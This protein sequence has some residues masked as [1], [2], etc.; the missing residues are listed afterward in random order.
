MFRKRNINNNKKAEIL[1]E[2][3]DN[4]NSSF[5]NINQILKLKNNIKILGKKR[6]CTFSTTEEYLNDKKKQKLNE[7][8]FY[9]STKTLFENNKNNAIR[10]NLIDPELPN[11]N[12]KTK[13]DSD[14]KFFGYGPIIAP[15]NIRS[16]CR[17][18]YAPG[19]CKDFKETGYCGFGETC[20]FVHD[21]SDYKLGWELEQEWNKLQ[22]EKELKKIKEG[23]YY[24]SDEE[25]S[26]E[27]EN[28]EDNKICKICNKEFVEP[29]VISCN[30]IFCEKCIINQYKNKNKK[31]I[32]CGNL[33]N[34]IFNKYVKGKNNNNNNNNNKKNIN[35]KKEENKEF[36]KIK[37]IGEK[38]KKGE[39]I[40]VNNL[41]DNY[42]DFEY[43]NSNKKDFNEENI[44]FENEKVKKKNKINYA[45]DWNYKSDYYKY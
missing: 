28:K 6:L 23:K 14:N 12:K 22:R 32:L 26:C 38:L 35:I 13:L 9:E 43:L 2:N 30:H 7:E 36:D 10:E 44:I 18:D 21:R 31:C 24:S 19:I 17:F 29:V 4:K 33:L 40:I 3:E 15:K 37:E 25:S 45:N 1:F 34:G 16:T 11:P 27:C 20:I 5:S 39:E 41:D 42:N 8:K